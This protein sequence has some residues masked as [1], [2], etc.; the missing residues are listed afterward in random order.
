[1]TGRQNKNRTEQKPE[2]KRSSTKRETLANNAAMQASGRVDA[3]TF[4]GGS[5]K[6]A[7]S[8]SPFKP[9]GG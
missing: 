5:G 9:N 2:S 4:W 1:L 8:G 6:L 3:R 7:Q